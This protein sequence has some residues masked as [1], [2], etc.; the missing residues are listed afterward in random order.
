MFLITNDPEAGYGFKGAR[1]LAFILNII[2]TSSG[3]IVADSN[4]SL[5]C[6]TYAQQM[7]LNH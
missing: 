2:A 1:T 4:I 7:P 3:F 6:K 5:L